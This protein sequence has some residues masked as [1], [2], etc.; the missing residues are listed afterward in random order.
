APPADDFAPFPVQSDEVSPF[1]PQY[2]APAAPAPAPAAPEAP[3]A[4]KPTRAADIEGVKSLL[5]NF[6]GSAQLL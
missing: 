5:E 1:S 3:G 2:E 6:G 4:P